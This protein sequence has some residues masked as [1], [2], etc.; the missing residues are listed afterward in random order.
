MFLLAFAGENIDDWLRLQD[1]QGGYGNTGK[2]DRFAPD[3][4]S[5]IKPLSTSP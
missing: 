1:G 3:Y 4:F 2:A 5:G